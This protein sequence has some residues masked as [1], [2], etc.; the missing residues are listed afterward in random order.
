MQRRVLSLTVAVLLCGG[1]SGGL[2]AEASPTDRERA[3]PPILR[4][5]LS[6]SAFLASLDGEL[7]TPSGG[8][9]GTTSSNRPTTSEI[10][11]TGLEIHALTDFEL[12]LRDQHTIHFSYAALAQSGRETLDRQ[13][14]SQGQTIPENVRV[15]SRLEIPFGRLGYR[16]DWL[17]L[18]LGRWSLAPEVGAARID[19]RY[20]LRSEQAT[21][22]VDRAYVL[23]FAYW[24]FQL[25]GPIRDRLH[26]EI[27]LFA[28]AGLSNVVSLDS[29][30]R[31]LYRIAENDFFAASLLLGLRGVWLHYK[32]DQK[33]E[34]N[35]INVRVGAY[36]TRP[37]AGVHAGVRVSY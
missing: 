9:Q 37:W 5:N 15:K 24:G 28:S 36:S 18:P 11:L 23:Y 2:R 26:A 34:Q 35:D 32:D 12:T 33:E 27:D 6:A 3:G 20:R 22:P 30:F 21:G 16:A 19:F 17:S 7:Q 4:V 14:V 8:A 29:D 13:L 25:R 10:G 1:L 31:L